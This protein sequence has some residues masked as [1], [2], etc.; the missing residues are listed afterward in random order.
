MGFLGRAEK[1]DIEQAARADHAFDLKCLERVLSV[2]GTQRPKESD[3][4]EELSLDWFNNEYN[5]MVRL[6]SRRS[7][8][9]LLDIVRRPTKSDAWVSFMGVLEENGFGMTA[10]FFPMDGVGLS[11]IHNVWSLS[12]IPG[13][14]RIMRPASSSDRGIII[15][16]AAPCLE[17]FVKDG[18]IKW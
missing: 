6:A 7:H 14:T 8:S 16:E 2:I 3:T 13:H 15:D 18:L 1:Y 4:E 10:M 5:P 9:S 11:I 17:A 12:A